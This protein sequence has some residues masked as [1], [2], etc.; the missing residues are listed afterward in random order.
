MRIKIENL[1]KLLNS[2]RIIAAI[3][4]VFLLFGCPDKPAEPKPAGKVQFVF[5]HFVDGVQALYNQMAYTNASG[6]SW[7]LS[8]VQ[9]FLSE[10]TLNKKDGNK[11]KLNKWIDYHYI[12]TDIPSTFT[13]DVEDSVDV[14]D[15][16]SVSFVF[17]FKGEKNIPF[18]FVNPPES[19]MFWPYYLGGDSGGYHYMKLNG[20]WLDS[21]Q[22]RRA[23]NFHL[24]VG[25]YQ[26]ENGNRPTD[27]DGNFYFVQNWFTVTLPAAFKMEDSAKVQITV[28][29]NLEKWFTTP[30]NYN[31]DDWGPDVMENQKAMKLISENGQDVFTISKILNL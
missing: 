17:G 26:D 4:L 22:Y 3:A 7:E 29:M 25:Q 24:G 6:N 8:E 28:R 20:F 5:E 13:W 1:R 21:S 18:M 31:H 16:E 30:N 19:Q 10:V 14:G 9:W 12:D 15:Y 2:L 27:E 11:L 23:F